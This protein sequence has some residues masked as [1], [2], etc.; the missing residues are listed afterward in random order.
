ME[1]LPTPSANSNDVDWN[2][3]SPDRS[4]SSLK[5]GHLESVKIVSEKLHSNLKL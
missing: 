1:Q 4:P 2:N 5:G 3:A